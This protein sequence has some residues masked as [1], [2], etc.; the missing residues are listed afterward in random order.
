[1]SPA[2][3]GKLLFYLA[4]AFVLPGVVLGIERRGV[5]PIW[6][7]GL[8]LLI[9]GGAVLIVYGALAYAGLATWIGLGAHRGRLAGAILAATGLACLG[10]GLDHLDPDRPWRVL[11]IPLILVGGLASLWAAVTRSGK[12]TA[13]LSGARGPLV[14]AGLWLFGLGWPVL[15]L[16]AVGVEP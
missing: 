15:I 7:D 8:I 14:V 16:W 13:G 12:L 10:G 11:T 3:R 6:A 4:G 1:M 9:P 5:P 2:L